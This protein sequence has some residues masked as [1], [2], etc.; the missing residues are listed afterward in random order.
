MEAGPGVVQGRGPVTSDTVSALNEGDS[1]YF[2]EDGLKVGGRM[3]AWWSY[4]EGSWCL[5]NPGVASQLLTFLPLQIFQ[6]FHQLCCGSSSGT[7]RAQYSAVVSPHGS[8]SSHRM[9][10]HNSGF[11]WHIW[12]WLWFPRGKEPCLLLCFR[13]HP[14]SAFSSSSGWERPCEYNHSDAQ[15]QRMDGSGN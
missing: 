2:Q 10:K 13:H 14:G 1:L 8:S 11:K 3:K 5:L 12:A 4:L 6:N 15:N 7:R 9:H